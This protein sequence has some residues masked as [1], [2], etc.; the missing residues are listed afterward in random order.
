MGD[1][2]VRPLPPF[3]FSLGNGSEMQVDRDLETGE[4]SVGQQDGG[5]HKEFLKVD[6]QVLERGMRG[7]IPS[8]CAYLQGHTEVKYICTWLYITMFD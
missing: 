2:L 3:Q 5:L 7:L 4:I 6:G 1:R 8:L